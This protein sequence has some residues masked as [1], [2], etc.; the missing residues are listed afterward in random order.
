[1][2][3]QASSSKRLKLSAVKFT[4]NKSF[5]TLVFG[6]MT[7]ANL[8]VVSVEKSDRSGDGFLQGL[9]ELMNSQS[10]DYRITFCMQRR[11]V[12]QNRSELNPPVKVRGKQ[13]EV[14]YPRKY[15]ILEAE[16]EMK[17]RSREVGKQEVEQA[18]Q[19]VSQ[20]CDCAAQTA[21]F[22]CLI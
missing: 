22:V 18:C 6:C 11:L 8:I 15:F 13:E 16:S 21:R 4:Q 5:N 2:S 7:K 9:E 14:Q 12:G 20:V 1:M 17:D 3:I 19:F 10:A